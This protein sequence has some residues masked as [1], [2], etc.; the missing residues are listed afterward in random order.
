MIT[1][2]DNESFGGIE[3]TTIV[4]FLPNKSSLPALQ[5]INLSQSSLPMAPIKVPCFTNGT[6]CEP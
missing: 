5:F 4:T 1:K 2:K 6:R 3:S